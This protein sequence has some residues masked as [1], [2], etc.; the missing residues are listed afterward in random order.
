ML[1]FTGDIE[2][3]LPEVVALRHDL[4]AHPELAYCEERTSGKVLEQLRSLA[5]LEIQ[6]GLAGGTGIVATLNGDK[7]GP[8]VLLRADMDA[9]P[10]EEDSALPYKSQHA[11]KMHACGHDG[12]TSMLIGAARVLTRC[13]DRLPGKVKFCFQPAEE[14]GAGGERMVADGVL[15]NPRVD[16]AFALHG[17]PDIPVG[18]IAT[19]PGP[20]LAAT[21][22][23]DITITARGGH[24]AYPHRTPDAIVAAAQFITNIQA[25]RARFVDPFDPVVISICMVEAGY[26]YNVLPQRCALKGTVRALR[27]EV[28]AR[29]RA[30]V[31]EFLRAT[32]ASFEVE[33]E[34]AYGT[35]YPAL[36]NDAACAALVADVGRE[37]L[38]A[39]RVSMDYPPGLGGEDFA[40]F[41]ERVPAAMFQLGLKRPSAADVA[42]LHNP[43]FDFNDAA[44]PHGIGMLCGIAQRY[45][46]H[47]GAVAPTR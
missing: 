39:E 37:L 28:H 29:A 31:G 17:W 45:L 2:A 33:A 10:I 25:I 15:E 7:P 8:C 34:L 6:D 36:T 32:A 24:A 19:R 16:A 43:R 12:H 1:D 41:A 22:P 21:A 3:I 38:G 42:G 44:L 46:E 4:H 40:Y 13:A 47:A 11:G 27:P 5:G 26:T 18:A 23:F 35:C 9:L 14:D 20:M 30:L